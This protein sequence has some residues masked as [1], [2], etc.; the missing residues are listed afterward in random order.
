M[1]K[2][3]QFNPKTCKLTGPVGTI[4]I[5]AADQMAQRFLM[6]VE[7]QCLQDNI[8]DITSKY[9]YCRQRYYQLLAD[10]KHGGLL[11]LQPEKTGPKTNYRRTDQAVR[12]VL[13]YRFLDPDA[14]PEVITQKLRQTHF[15]I[16]LRSV[17][18]IIADYGLQK[19]TL[20]PGPQKA[21]PR[22]THSRHRRKNPTQTR[23]R[24]QRR[25]GSSSTAGR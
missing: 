4:S 3:L 9:G 20:H 17:H 1:S 2:T 15:Q 6:I 16:S 23:R 24:A 11:A 21:A 10:F 25:K 14:S 8:A 5:Q 12:Q 22:D 18:R 19:K 7:G 13:R